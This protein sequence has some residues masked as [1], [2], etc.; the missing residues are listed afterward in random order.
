MQTKALLLR[1]KIYL[2]KRILGKLDDTERHF[3]DKRVKVLIY[4]LQVIPD[5]Y[6]FFLNPVLIS[7]LVDDLTRMLL[8]LPEHLHIFKFLL[9]VCV[10]VCFSLSLLSLLSVLKLSISTNPTPVMVYSSISFPFVSS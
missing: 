2:T 6:A 1:S 4:G 8:A 5:I 9:F 3:C 10:C 7:F